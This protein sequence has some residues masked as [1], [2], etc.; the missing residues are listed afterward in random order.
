S[1]FDIAYSLRAST[2]RGEKQAN[3]TFEEFRVIEEKAIELRTRELEISDWRIETGKLNSLSEGILIWAEGKDK[4][5]GKSRYGLQQSD[6]FAIYT[7]PPSPAELRAAL[8]IVNP[9]KVYVFSVSPRTEKTD[10]FLSHLA[11]M[12]KY[13]INNK[14]GKV[15]INELAVAT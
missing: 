3:L 8:E 6:E 9:K 2:F 14:S 11:G 7:T 1:K 4:D 13:A 12:A 10:E 15:S 5:K